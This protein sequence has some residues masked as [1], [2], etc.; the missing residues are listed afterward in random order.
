MIKGNEIIISNRKAHR[1][2]FVLES[3]ETGIE[4]KGSEVKSLRNRRGNLND[5]FAR[6][7]GG[8]IFLF[9]LHISPY[10]FTSIEPPDPLRTRK[11]LLHKYQIRK[12]FGCLS[13]GGQTLIPLKLYFKRGKVK[14][15][16][17]LVKGKKQYDKREAIKRREHNLEIRRSL[18]RRR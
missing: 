9:N 2:Y 13:T 12:L 11:L 1:D 10:S 17:A 16:L 8:E 7:V 15:E 6:V 14:V 5:S 4:L 18:D 3:F